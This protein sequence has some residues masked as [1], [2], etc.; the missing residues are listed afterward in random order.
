MAD[1]RVFYSRDVKVAWRN[2]LSR[3]E[4]VEPYDV[5]WVDGEGETLAQF[6][7]EAGLLTDGPSIPKR[8]R[9]IVP[10]YGHHFQ[11]AVTH[12]DCYQHHHGL[13]R[14]QA[15]LLFLEG[16][17]DEGVPWLRRRVMYHAVSLFG[18]SSWKPEDREAVEPFPGGLD[19]LD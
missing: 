17:A 16:M 15:D 11:P 18:G 13:D 19:F 9:G 1:P 14:T 10:W 5:L 6:T 8:L 2:H 12:D 3:F 7:V 4:L